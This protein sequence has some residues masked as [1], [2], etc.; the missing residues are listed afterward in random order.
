MPFIAF[1]HRFKFQKPPLRL[2]LVVPFLLQLSAVVGLTGWLSWRNG[3]KAV[4][5][6]ILQL[7]SGVTESIDQHTKQ[8]LGTPHLFHQINTSAIRNGG[9]DVSDF[10]ALKQHF[11]SQIQIDPAVDYIYFGNE[12]GDFLGVQNLP[13]EDQTVLKVRSSETAPNRVIYELDSEGNRGEFISKKEYDPR[14]RP[15]YQAAKVQRKPTWSPIYHSAHLGVLQITPVVPIFSDDGQFRGA[16]ATNLILSEISNF[17]HDLDIS[18]AG[19]AFIIERSGEMV[20]SSTKETY[21]VTTSANEERLQAINSQEP[22]VQLAMQTLLDQVDDLYSIQ[23]VQTFSYRLN[24]ARHLV[25]VTPLKDGRGLDWL[26][27][28]VI[29]E[30]D[31][32][33]QIRINTYTTIGLCVVALLVATWVG[34]YTARWISGPILRLSEAT[35]AI[36]E[37]DLE[38]TVPVGRS[39]ELSILAASF[40]R[41]AKQ[42]QESFDE[43]ERTNEKLEQRVE[44]RTALLRAEQEKSEQ[45]LLNILPEPIAQQLKQGQ[46]AIAEHFDEVTILFADIVDFTPLSARLDPIELVN[47]LN[48]IF[49]AFDQLAEQFGLEKIKTIGD[50]YMVAA[51]LP[52]RR[53]DHAEAMAE[54]ALAMQA[55]MKQFREEK[56]ADQRFQREL[57]VPLSLRIGINTGI[58]V[59][60]VIGTKKFI[61]DLWGDAVNIASRM[62]SQGQPGFIQV[63]EAT[64][65][66]LKNKYVFKERGSVA[67]KGKGD[68]M[69]YWL[70][71]KRSDA[72]LESY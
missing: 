52:V 42:L 23:T 40:N 4:N 17:L 35:H 45:L 57:G 63:T 14:S 30:T 3:Q 51:G 21:I 54:M 16:L 39:K 61:Y 64:Y 12:A 59:A 70:L 19:H 33:A 8:Y 27:I 41:M 15:W 56:A 55:C 48:Q 32:M 60:G 58:V 66:R 25:Q 26:S 34:I 28:V 38:Q 36:A 53:E 68:M 2:V 46:S 6:V 43:L 9:L 13:D 47:L 37:G 24:K 11:W 65:A 22:T 62:E 1:F 50:A 31:F 67:V 20:A 49:S 69:A 18:P 44:E 72:N 5:N 10:A 29:P 7:S 71:G